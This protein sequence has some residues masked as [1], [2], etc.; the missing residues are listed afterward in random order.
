M[1]Q[2]TPEARRQ[3]SEISSAEEIAQYSLN[4]LIIV[5]EVRF[6]D[7]MKHLSTIPALRSLHFKPFFQIETQPMH[8][9]F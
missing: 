5:S 8:I 9:Y 6:I 4:V 2:P 3:R 7:E 1:G